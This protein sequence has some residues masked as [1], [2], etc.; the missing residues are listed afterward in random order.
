[1][2]FNIKGNGHPMTCLCRHRGQV[3]VQILR[4]RNPALERGGRSASGSSRFTLG[5]DPVPIVQEA[6]WASGPVWTAWEVSPSPGFDPR[7]VQTAANRYTEYAIPAA[8]FQYT[9]FEEIT[10]LPYLRFRNLFLHF[11]KLLLLLSS[12]SSPP[13]SVKAHRLIKVTLHGS[14]TSTLPDRR[15]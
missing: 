11:N 7:T 8:K 1:M 3:N 10:F 9:S 13:P 2:N 14:S 15:L 4:I 12:S 6:G 5:K